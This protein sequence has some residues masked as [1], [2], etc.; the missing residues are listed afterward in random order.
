MFR[1]WAD[2]GL[3]EPYLLSPIEGDWAVSEEVAHEGFLEFPHRRDNFILYLHCLLDR[4]E[5]MHN[6]PLFIKRKESDR[7]G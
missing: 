6:R 1:Q 7:V 3:L 2:F 4:R 5:H